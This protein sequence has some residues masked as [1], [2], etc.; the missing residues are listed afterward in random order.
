VRRVVG[1]SPI[2]LLAAGCAKDGNGEGGVVGGEGRQS[3]FRMW[4]TKGGG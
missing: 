1:A 4:G 2:H 3:G